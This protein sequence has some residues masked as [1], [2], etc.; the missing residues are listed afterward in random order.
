MSAGSDS[1]LPTVTWIQEHSD[2]DSVELS[3]S[4][5]SLDDAPLLGSGRTSFPSPYAPS[6]VTPSLQPSSLQ[7]HPP[8]LSPPHAHSSA[9]HPPGVITV[10]VHVGG[11]TCAACSGA[12]HSALAALPRVTR[13]D[14]ALATEVAQVEVD[15]DGVHGGKVDAEKDGMTGSYSAAMA[16]REV[17]G[18]IEDAGFEG[19]LLGT[20]SASTSLSVNV[21]G[22]V[23][24]DDVA[25]CVEVAVAAIMGVRN[26]SIDAK[27]GGME[28][29]YDP[30][31]TGLRDIVRAVEG[32]D[33]KASGVEKK[34]GKS[35]EGL[36]EEGQEKEHEMA[37]LRGKGSVDSAAVQQVERGGEE[38]EGGVRGRERGR[39]RVV[40]PS[41]LG[42]YRVQKT[43]EAMKAREQFLI[44]AMYAVSGGAHTMNYVYRI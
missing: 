38:R 20:S 21:E 18:A 35:N 15:L 22:L 25:A 28:V 43:G 6:P 33:L 11:M 9:V 10:R 5:A 14:V 8:S 34:T 32:V 27:G 41:V 30:E 26:V 36:N 3:P 39:L 1:P 42:S 23:G 12:V 13:A 2:V 17:L 37:S 40:L 4:N 44:A 29:E 19:K 16:V 7:S 31:L 24:R